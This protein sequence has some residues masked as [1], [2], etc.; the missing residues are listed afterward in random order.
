[1]DV[2]HKIAPRFKIKI[3]RE[4][5]RHCKRCTVNCS[6]GV[7]EYNGN[8]IVVESEKCVACQRCA[9]MCPQ[10]AISIVPGEIS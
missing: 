8:Q 3:D 5:C 7:L 9:I 6:F 10:D 2:K 4:L 1:M